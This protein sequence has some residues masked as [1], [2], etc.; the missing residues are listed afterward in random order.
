MTGRPAKKIDERMRVIADELNNVHNSDEHHALY[1]IYNMFAD[2][3]PDIAR[4]VQAMIEETFG[5]H[6]DIP[7]TAV[8]ALTEIEFIYGYALKFAK[9]EWSKISR[10]PHNILEATDIAQKAI[11]KILVAGTWNPTSSKGEKIKYIKST[12]SGA[13]IDLMRKI[14]TIVKGDNTSVELVK[15]SDD[16]SPSAEDEIMKSENSED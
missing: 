16:K 15:L 3:H 7:E 5:K 11:E 1:D 6:E 13:R 14:T 9:T 12:V 8:K 2:K 10:V 4:A